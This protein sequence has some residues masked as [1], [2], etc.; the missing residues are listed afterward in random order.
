M[1][2]LSAET[3]GYYVI[4]DLYERIT[5]PSHNEYNHEEKS[6]VHTFRLSYYRPNWMTDVTSVVF[7]VV[8]KGMDDYEY[9]VDTKVW[10]QSLDEM[11]ASLL[12]NSPSLMPFRSTLTLKTMSGD[13]LT[14]DIDYSDIHRMPHQQIRKFIRDQGMNGD[15]CIFGDDGVVKNLENEVLPRNSELNVLVQ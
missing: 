4:E 2:T 7:Y 15:V 12:P 6:I 5:L 8:W 9:S 11:V 13:M 10:Y 3:A 14:L 1:Y